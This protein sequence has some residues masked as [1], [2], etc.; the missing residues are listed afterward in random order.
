[1]TIFNKKVNLREFCVITLTKLFEN[2]QSEVVS[3]NILP[4]LSLESGW[5]NCS[6]DKLLILLSLQSLFGKVSLVAMATF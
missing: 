2:L 1:M 5:S 6:P 3:E 4:C